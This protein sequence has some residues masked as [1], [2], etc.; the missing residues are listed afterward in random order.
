MSANCRFH[1]AS[2]GRHFASLVAFDLHRDGPYEER[3]CADPA[4]VPERMRNLG[5]GRCRIGGGPERTGVVV[6]GVVMSAAARARLDALA[7]KSRA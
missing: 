7:D 1:C 2:C 6:W 4:T 3:T 5:E